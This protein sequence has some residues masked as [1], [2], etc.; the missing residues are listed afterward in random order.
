MK[1]LIIIALLALAGLA[2]V[3]AGNISGRVICGSQPMNGV[4]VSDGVTIVLTDR[5]GRYTIDSDKSGGS[6]FVIT[7]PAT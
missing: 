5:D 7:L 6:V 4:A 1:R 3:W 2:S